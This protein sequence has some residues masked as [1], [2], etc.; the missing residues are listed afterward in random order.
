MQEVAAVKI[1]ESSN[2]T[3][4]FND[5]GNVIGSKNS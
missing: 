1:L 2:V 4:I 3:E 5:S